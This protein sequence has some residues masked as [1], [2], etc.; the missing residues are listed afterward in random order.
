M[1][2]FDREEAEHL[3]KRLSGRSVSYRQEMRDTPVTH[4]AELIQ[5]ALFLVLGGT[6]EFDRFNPDALRSEPEV[7]AILEGHGE[8]ANDA[9]EEEMAN[10]FNAF[11]FS[12]MDKEMGVA[13]RRDAFQLHD[14][15]YNIFRGSSE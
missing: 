4:E 6:I 9:F 15:A 12:L 5:S 8:A 1:D 14:N 11:C 7:S 3:L 13:D 2:D 10:I